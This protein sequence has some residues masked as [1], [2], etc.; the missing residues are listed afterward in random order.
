VTVSQKESVSKTKGR[1]AGGRR[2]HSTFSLHSPILNDSSL[3]VCFQTLHTK[4][5]IR[6]WSS[7]HQSSRSN[8]GN[9]KEQQW[10][11][12]DGEEDRIEPRVQVWWRFRRLIGIPPG[13]VSSMGRSA[14]QAATVYRSGTNL[15]E[16]QGLQ[17]RFPVDC[18]SLSDGSGN[19]LVTAPIGRL[20]EC[21]GAHYLF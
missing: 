20:Q 5:R 2:V 9:V 4:N 18:S 7:T 10:E 19:E 15:Q 12:W 16:W 14:L 1:V 8:Q 13:E 6:C 3:V 11:G 21:V 17:A